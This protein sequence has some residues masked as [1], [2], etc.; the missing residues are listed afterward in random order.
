MWL[1]DK[2]ILVTG[3]KGFLGRNLVKKL[4]KLDIH[5]DLLNVIDKKDYD[6]RDFSSCIEAV[7]DMD[8]VIH[9]AANVGGIGYNQ[10][11]PGSI[12]YDNILMGFSLLEASR[13]S[14]VKKVIIVGTTCGYP[15]HTKVPFKEEDFWNGYPEEITAPYGIAKKT[16]QVLSDS[17]RKEYNFNS[18]FLIPTNLYGPG[19]NFK[20]EDAHVIPA[21]IE[22]IHTAKINKN[23]F[24][25]VWGTGNATRE[26]LYVDDCVEAIIM[27]ANSL[28]KSEPFNVGTGQETSIKNIV[29]AIC[30]LLDYDGKII[31]DKSKPDGQPRRCLDVSKIYNEIGFKS[32]TGILEGLKET[33]NWYLQ[34]KT[35]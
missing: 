10:K 17:Y 13:I 25:T 33:I 20:G 11:Y 34:N 15:K 29:K 12:L 3:G 21:L 2:K 14:S 27:A 31:W 4:Q 23:D 7:K 5:S 35:Q 1:T 22:K 16:L 24:V 28:N 32:R 6:L 19:D 26:F 30:N 9:L 18:I 8:V